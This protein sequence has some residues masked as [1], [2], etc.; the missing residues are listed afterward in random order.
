M[1]ETRGLKLN[2]TREVEW[3]V[4]RIVADRIR[5]WITLSGILDPERN[6][7]VLKV[8]KER[9]RKRQRL[10]TKIAGIVQELGL[11]QTQINNL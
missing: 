6:R 9:S 11:N 1:I 3:R 2:R 4:W 7:D 5:G 10:R 8:L